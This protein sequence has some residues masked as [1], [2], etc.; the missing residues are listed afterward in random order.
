MS[1]HFVVIGAQRSGTTYLHDLLEAHPE[2]AMARPARPEPKVF[3]ADEVVERG[4]ASYRRAWFAHATG[5]TVLGEKSTSYIESAAAAIRVRAVL[6]DARIVVQLRDPIER[7]VSNWKFTRASGL[8]DLSLPEAIER[9]L[10]GRRDWDPKRSSVSPYSYLERGRYAEQLVPW[11]ETFPGLVRVQFLE[12]LVADPGVIGDL[13]R[14][15]GVDATVRPDELG[16]PVHVS[17]EPAGDL[18]EDLR[19]RMR[20]WYTKHD[21]ELSEMLGVELPWPAPTPARSTEP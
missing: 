8:E 14:W 21:R 19:S 16:L 20:D 18:G 6:G 15:L 10:T 7:A 12:D 4:A 17:D 9:N 13:Y 3:L 1:D 2:I 11:L 5:E